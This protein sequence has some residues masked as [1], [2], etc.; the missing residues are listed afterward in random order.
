[1]AAGQKPGGAVRT[2]AETKN[3][4]RDSW[5]VRAAYAPLNPRRTTPSE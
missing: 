5:G 2:G 1:M 3:A 4:R